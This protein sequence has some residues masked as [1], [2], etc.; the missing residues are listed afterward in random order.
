[1]RGVPPR[2]A[3]AYLPG[4]DDLFLTMNQR[5]DLDAKTPGDW[6]AWVT[7]GK[8]WGFPGCYGQDVRACA[9]MGE[10]VAELG[11]HAGRVGRR[12]RRP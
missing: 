3:Y 9:D 8:D 6:L 7:A 2:P 5:D 10:V 12:V 1:M 4:T 11:T